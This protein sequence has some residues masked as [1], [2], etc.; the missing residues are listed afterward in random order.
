MEVTETR[1]LAQAHV[2]SAR[3]WASAKAQNFVRG[4]RRT[5]SPCALD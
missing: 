1:A 2:R 5:A 3:A 4:A